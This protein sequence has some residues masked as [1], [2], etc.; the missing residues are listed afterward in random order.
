MVQIWRPRNNF[1]AFE[2][3]S[4]MAG[5]KEKIALMK[6]LQSFCYPII[7][8]SSLD[9][10]SQPNICDYRIQQSSHIEGKGWGDQISTLANQSRGDT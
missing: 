2:T 6:K 7:Q 8:S 1:C 4:K 10:A 3:L 5:L 9:S